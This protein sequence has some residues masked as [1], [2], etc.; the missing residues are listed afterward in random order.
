M[1]TYYRGMM[2]SSKS[3]KHHGILGQKWGVKQG[4]PYPLEP[5]RHSSNEN[6]KRW[7]S[8]LNKSESNKGNFGNKKT[9]TSE[10]KRLIAIGV[11]AVAAGSLAYYEYKTKNI[12]TFAGNL[13]YKSLIDSQRT[14]S[15]LAESAFDEND[16]KEH[17]DN[18]RKVLNEER[19][20][21]GISDQR[22]RPDGLKIES[23]KEIP[24]LEH[25]GSDLEE[26][27]KV[28]PFY[29][30]RD[31]DTTS[32]CGFCSMAFDLRK[33]GYDVI[34]CEGHSGTTNLDESIF[35]PGSKRIFRHGDYAESACIPTRPMNNK[36]IS[37]VIKSFSSEKGTRGIIAVSWGNVGGGHDMNYTV[38]DKGVLSLIDSQCGKVYTGANLRV[39]LSTVA[40]VDSI[41][42]DNIE[43][44][45][46][47][48]IK[49]KIIK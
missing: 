41:R 12:S 11:A 32:N 44:N 21:E 29:N 36:D 1:G 24:K 4:P 33:R 43:P 27:R 25:I 8:S 6:K 10:Q 3:L 17:S 46:E 20:A 14:R 35:F 48:L 23:V 19:R 42:T 18:L 45:I 31:I 2:F 30:K 16:R 40:S 5:N 37:K 13:K 39:F 47:D 7:D 28:N 26:A 49:L 22:L 34:A 15:R 38:S 9:L